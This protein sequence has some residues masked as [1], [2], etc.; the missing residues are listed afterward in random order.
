MRWGPGVR[1]GMWGAM[2]APLALAIAVLLGLGAMPGAA[3]ALPIYSARENM[4]CTNCHIDPSGGGLRTPFGF[5]Y[6]RNR[7]ALAP[8]DSFPELPTEQPEITNNLPVGGDLRFL[9]DALGRRH[10][11]GS[12]PNEVSSFLRMQGAFYISYAPIEPVRLYY[13][14]DVNGTRDLWGKIGG[15]PY[16]TYVRIGS[17]RTP[18]GLRMGDHTIYER[19]DFE[20]PLSFLGYDVRVPD[21]GLEIGVVSTEYFAQAALTNGSGSG[22]DSDRNKAFT[23]RYVRFYGPF[24]NGLSVQL[25]SDGQDPATERIRYGTFGTLAAH[26]QIVLIGSID[27]GEDE[28]RDDLTRTLLGWGEVDWFHS[29]SLRFRGRYEFMD[30]NREA[31]FADSERYTIGAD[32]IPY[33][34]TEVQAFYRFTSNESELDTEEIAAVVHFYF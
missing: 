34:F 14:Q 21:I 2:M 24:M 29:R 8:E 33:P 12:F 1:M 9:Y 22:F 19:E 30:R 17:F 25:D 15:L 6:L 7:H 5:D 26:E 28:T 27:L 20:T 23:G 11:S 16:G 32:W 10:E 31:E 18:Y 4:L 3:H 13:Q